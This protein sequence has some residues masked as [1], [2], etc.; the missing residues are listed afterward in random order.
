V[1]VTTD[2]LETEMRMAVEAAVEL[3]NA[4]QSSDAVRDDVREILIEHRYLGAPQ[5]TDGDIDAVIDHFGSVVEVVIAFP[6]SDL[7]TA[8]EAVNAALDQYQVEP[9]L[10][11]H[12]GS[13][14]HIHWTEPEARFEDHVVIDILMALAHTLCDSGVERFGTCS[15]ESCERVYFDTTRNLSRRFCSDSRCASRTHTAAH[16]ARQQLD[17]GDR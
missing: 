9:S 17:K 3:T 4:C 8:V 12:H 6:G 10:R 11:S 14:L 1:Y 15:A 7:G 2:S 13:P 16:R 5:A